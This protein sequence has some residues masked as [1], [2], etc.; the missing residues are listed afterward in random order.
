MKNQHREEF[1]DFLKGLA[2]LLMIQVHLMELFAN[3]A[4]FDGIAGKISLL[5]GGPP[6]APLFMVIMGY[7]VAKAAKPPAFSLKRAVRLLLTGLFLNIGLNTHLFILIASGKVS[8]ENPLHYLFGVDILFLAG[9]SIML[10]AVLARIAGRGIA[11]WLLIL[12]A[13]FLINH[14]VPDYQGNNQLMVY[15]LAFIKSREPWSYFP[16]IPWFVYPVTGV[17]LYRMEKQY[18]IFSA[19]AK[20]Q[21]YVGFIALIML[22]TGFKQGISTSA[23]LKAYYHHGFLYFIWATSFLVCWALVWFQLYKRLPDSLA[24]KYMMWAGRKVTSLYVAQWLIIGNIATGLYRTQSPA[25]L[26]GWF[27]LIVAASSL[28]TYA[29]DRYFRTSGVLKKMYCKRW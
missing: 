20:T 24:V 1:A 26:A 16:L 17:I 21:L 12:S 3:P 28:I 2:V 4:T 13:I 6:A 25:A 18:E 23:D 8:Q 14:L 9:L 10:L 11:G 22:I 19:S 27:V 29:Y 7:F 5:L 15:L